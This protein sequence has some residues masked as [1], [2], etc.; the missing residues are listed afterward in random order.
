MKK[1][2]SRR[3]LLSVCRNDATPSSVPY[4][5]DPSFLQ[6]GQPLVGSVEIFCELLERP[7]APNRRDDGVL[8]N[9]Q[10]VVSA[11]SDFLTVAVHTILYERDIYPRTSFLSARKYNYPVRQNRHPKVCKWIQDAVAAVEVELLKVR[12][13]LVS[14]KE[15][16]LGAGF[17]STRCFRYLLVHATSNINFDDCMFVTRRSIAAYRRPTRRPMVRVHR[18][19]RIILTILHAS[20]TSLGLHK[21]M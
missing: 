4:P 9:Y 19:S 21:V 7:M 12:G 3:H 8:D 11:F 20:T 13:L 16:A 2:K 18:V 1:T 14:A 6:P 17:R 15:R 5:S 10:A